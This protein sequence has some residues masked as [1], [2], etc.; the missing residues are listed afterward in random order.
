MSS[1]LLDTFHWLVYI[2]F[3][4]FFLNMAHCWEF[5]TYFTAESYSVSLAQPSV[6]WHRRERKGVCHVRKLP[7]KRQSDLKLFWEYCFSGSNKNQ[8]SNTCLAKSFLPHSQLE[9]QSEKLELSIRISL[10][11]RS[12]IR[13]GFCVSIMGPGGFVKQ[14]KLREKKSRD[15]VP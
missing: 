12:P 2:I 14:K 11:N 9:L 10:Q 3:Q 13:K 4:I 6:I 1:D 8:V 7:L 5:G 15:T